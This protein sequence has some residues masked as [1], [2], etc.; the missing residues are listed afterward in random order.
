[1]FTLA[2]LSENP[3]SYTFVIHL[4]RASIELASGS[5]KFL[6][7]LQSTRFENGLR[8]EIRTLV[9]TIVVRYDYAELVDE[10][11]HIEKNLKGK[12]PSLVVSGEGEKESVEDFSKMSKP[13]FSRGSDWSGDTRFGCIRMQQKT[14]WGL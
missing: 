9:K 11:L 8:S 1:M 12:R 7:Y 13:T 10:T 4:G 3:I 6:L 2:L 5:F 14:F